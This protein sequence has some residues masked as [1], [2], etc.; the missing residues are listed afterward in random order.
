MHSPICWKGQI[1]LHIPLLDILFE[2]TGMLFFGYQLAHW[3]FHKK[4]VK[5]Y[6]KKN[7]KRRIEMT[8]LK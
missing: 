6:A 2:I 5:R 7:N 1:M 3:Y 8:R 4:F